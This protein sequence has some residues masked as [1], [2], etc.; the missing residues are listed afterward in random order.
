MAFKKIMIANR[1]EIAI[2]ILRSCRE[3]GIDTVGIHSTVDEECLHVKLCD[4]SVCIGPAKSLLSYLNIPSIL[5]A[6]EIT[7]SD[8]IHP[9][10]GFLSENE[11]FA[12]L[13]AKWNITFIGPSVECIRLMGD[14]ILS[15]E[16]AKKAGVPTLEPI[17]ITDKS[18]ADIMSDVKK[19]GLPVLIKASA[20][21]GG[22]GMKRIDNF[23]D[24]LPS[25]IRLQ[26][27]A[28][29]AFGDGTLFIEKY[30][31]NPRHIEVQILADKHGNVIHLGER[32][33]TIQRRF[34]K[35]VEESPSPVLTDKLRNEI[36]DSA[37]RLAKF[38]GYDSVGTVEYLYDQDEKK[39]YFMEMNTRIQVEHP[40]TEQR[41]GIDL[42]AE[43]ILSAQGEKLRYKQSDIT[44]RGHSLECRINAENPKTSMPSPGL[45][46]HYHRPGGIGIRVDDYIYS[47]YTVLPY[48]DSMLAKIIVLAPTRDDCIRRMQ[49]ALNEMVIKGIQTNTELHERIMEDPDFRGNNYS[50][51]FISLKMS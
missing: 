32:D 15:K 20:G 25:I 27:E 1:G 42:V 30:I 48:Y 17:R 7:G 36:C 34:Q 35:L 24:V 50:T 2:R 45:V 22:K 31:T 14:K 41:T 33:C 49:R 10:F 47:G 11:E 51:N 19:M 37:V 23:D 29:A 5:S 38:V 44:F 9:G 18:D 4:E 46:T 43:Q 16:T 26:E 12:E 39:F 8:A 28:K 40:V 3:L 13:C 6:A 21:G